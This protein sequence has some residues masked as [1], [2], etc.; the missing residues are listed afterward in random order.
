MVTLDPVVEPEQLSQVIFLGSLARTT[1]FPCSHDRCF[2]FPTYEGS[3]SVFK[4][5]WT[6]EKVLPLAHRR[7]E[8]PAWQ[9]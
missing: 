5:W 4:G 2:F 1:Q 6:R 7:S 3:D 9:A 8:V